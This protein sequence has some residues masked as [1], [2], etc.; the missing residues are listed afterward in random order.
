MVNRT[1]QA[2]GTYTAPA[3]LIIDAATG[4]L[5]V[6]ASTPGTYTVTYTFT[7]GN[8]PNVATTS[9]NIEGIPVLVISN[10][11]AVCAPNSID[12][13]SPGITTGSTTGLT[14]NYYSDAAG[15]VAVPAPNAITVT[16]IYY[17]KGFLPG[18]C[19]T[20]IKPVLVVINEQPVMTTSGDI[21]ICRNESTTLTAS[22]PGNTVNW[23]S[24]PASN[25]LTVQPTAATVYA[26][27]ATS[28]LGCTVQSSVTVQIRNFD[29]LLSAD[30]LNAPIGSTVLLSTL[31]DQTYEVIA[32]MPLHY[33][34]NQTAPTQSFVMNDSAKLFSVVARSIEGCVDTASLLINVDHDMKDFFI[35]N[36]MTPNG[37]GKNDVFRVY[38]SSIKRVEIRI[39]NSWGELIHQTSDNQKGWDGTYK[40]RQQPAGV[41]IYTVN[42]TM[43]DDVKIN[44]KGNINL[45]R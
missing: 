5:D 19:E 11:S 4:T 24:G 25:S 7:D 10:P 36:A 34:P 41:Y 8:C 26:V 42:A 40:G 12:L 1:G 39:Y 15:T 30:K 38:G 6:P 31:S 20:D 18:G 3:G 14:F 17:I 44:R 35:P 2:G 22:S 32:W 28:P 45:I 43:Y 9:V 33:L 21:T 16:G 13:T 37:D 29:V 23:M 27:T